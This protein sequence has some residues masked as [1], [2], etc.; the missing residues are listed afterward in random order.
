MEGDERRHK[1]NET[2]TFCQKSDLDYDD[3]FSFIKY[4]GAD[5]AQLFALANT[6]TEL[7]IVSTISV[8][9]SILYLFY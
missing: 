9:W 6:I 5:D 3:Y 1:E 2:Y 4:F 7:G 8:E